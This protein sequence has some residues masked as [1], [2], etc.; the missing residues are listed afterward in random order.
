MITQASRPQLDAVHDHVVM[1]PSNLL[2]L[3][4]QQ[5]NVVFQGGDKRL[6]DVAELALLIL[7]E[8]GKVHNEECI[9]LA[10]IR[11]TEFLAQVDSQPGQDR[12]RS[13]IIIRLKE[14]Q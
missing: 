9:P 3:A 8:E 1:G 11:A 5:G 7:L 13:I 2:G 10:P 12:I 14:E 6:M 4:L